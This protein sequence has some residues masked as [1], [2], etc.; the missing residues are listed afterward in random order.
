MNNLYAF[1]DETK[2]S[3]SRGRL[4]L[5]ALSVTPGSDDSLEAEHGI[6]G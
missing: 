2:M 3:A 5:P 4:E 1:D 6:L